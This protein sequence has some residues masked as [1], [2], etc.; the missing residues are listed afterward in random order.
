MKKSIFYISILSMM[1]CFGCYEEELI[2]SKPGGEIIGPVTNLDYS[3][4]EEGV[5]LTWDLPSSYPEDVIEPVNVEINV[6]V[7]GI[8]EGGAITLVEAPTS[9]TFT[10]YDPSKKY[11]FTVKIFANVDITGEPY[12]SGLT[13]SLGKTLEL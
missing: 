5:H 1:F 10:E 6:S 2:T 9:Y 8:E 3:I 13:Y 11:R 12:A 7:D 4:V